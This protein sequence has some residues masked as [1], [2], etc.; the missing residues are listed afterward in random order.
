MKKFQFTLQAL[1]D[2]RQRLEEEAQSTLAKEVGVLQDLENMRDL[3]LKEAAHATQYEKLNTLIDLQNRQYALQ[4]SHTLLDQVSIKIEAIDKQKAAVTWARNALVK[5]TQ[6]KKV[7]EIH[8]DNLHQEWKKK[9]R[10][11]ETNQTDEQT[12]Q[13][14][15]SN[16]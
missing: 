15:G 7:L 5:A 6:D 14:W 13:R 11:W 16:L 10:K 12:S 3:L 2:H 9:R 8:K 4:Y 1:L